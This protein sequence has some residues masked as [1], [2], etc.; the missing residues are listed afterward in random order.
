ME[1]WK[2]IP[3]YGGD[4]KISDLGRIKSLKN[5]EVK[6]LKLSLNEKGYFQVGLSKKGRTK[7]IH[8]HVLVAITFLNHKPCGFEK[9]V[10]HKNR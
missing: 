4:Y 9:V 10:N 7:T 6:F 1:V 3:N 5:N 2:D 8:V